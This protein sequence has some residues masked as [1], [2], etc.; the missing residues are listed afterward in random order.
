MGAPY[1]GI[2][3]APW[4]VDYSH[5]TRSGKYVE[6]FTTQFAIVFFHID[7]KK[8]DLEVVDLESFELIEKA[9]LR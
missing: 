2:D 9:T 3:E 1:Y 6:K 8:V 7:G 5:E 4:H